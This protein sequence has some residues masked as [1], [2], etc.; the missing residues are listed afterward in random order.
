MSKEAKAR[1]R[2]TESKMRLKQPTIILIFMLLL[3]ICPVAFVQHS[4]GVKINPGMSKISSSFADAKFT[5]SGNAGIYYSAKI[6]NRSVFGAELLF[7]QIE[8][9]ELTEFEGTDT[10]GHP[11]GEISISEVRRH[12]SYIGLPIY[13]GIKFKRLMINIGFQTSFVLFSSARD[14]FYTG[15]EVLW[16]NKFDK[17]NIDCFDFGGRIGLIFDITDRFQIEG[18]YYY[19]VSNILKFDSCVLKNQQITIGLRYTFFTSPSF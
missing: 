9:L 14:L 16:D 1:I 6:N 10:G 5:L 7:L 18:N 11:T 17:L 8:G 12:I 4:F 2:I 19:G 15:D 13:Y 3:K